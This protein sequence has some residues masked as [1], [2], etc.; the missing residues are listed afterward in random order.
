MKKILKFVA[1]ILLVVL[2][3]IQF[4]RPEKNQSGYESVASF[5]KDTK[6]NE[7]VQSILKNHCYDCHSNQTI[8]PWYAEIAPI[9]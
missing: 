6:P 1:I 2:V 5:E 9:S 3:I 8:Y 4:V 7:Q